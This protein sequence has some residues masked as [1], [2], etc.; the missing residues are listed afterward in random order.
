MKERERK[1]NFLTLFRLKINSTSE[2]KMMN[3]YWKDSKDAYLSVLISP[4]DRLFL[5]IDHHDLLVHLHD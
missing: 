4:G 3:D 1:N 5:S 2:N